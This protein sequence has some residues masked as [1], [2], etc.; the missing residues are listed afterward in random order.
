[1]AKQRKKKILYNC[2]CPCCDMPAKQVRNNI[3]CEFCDTE[4]LI[5]KDGGWRVVRSGV[6]H[7]LEKKVDALERKRQGGFWGRFWESI[8]G[9]SDD[10]DN[11]NDILPRIKII[12]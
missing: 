1:M 8:F 4:F 3:F 2:K 11:D 9:G 10:N 5:R 7:R 6:L 12:R